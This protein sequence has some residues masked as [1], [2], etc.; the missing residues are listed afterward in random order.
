MQPQTAKLHL[1]VGAFSAAEVTLGQG[2]E[3]AGLS[4]TDFMRELARRQIPLHY[5]R[6]EFAEDLQ[7]IARLN[8]KLDHA[9][10]Q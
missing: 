6:D 5:D 8:E 3:I 1:A 10:H 4:E 9:R 7:T 2:A